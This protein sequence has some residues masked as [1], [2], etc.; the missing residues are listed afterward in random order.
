MSIVKG[1]FS[2]MDSDYQNN[3]GVNGTKI[4]ITAL[5]KLY[6]DDGKAFFKA[7]SDSI[8]DSKSKGT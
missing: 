5:H 3:S 6:Q 8:Y 1:E 4:K 2:K 7:K